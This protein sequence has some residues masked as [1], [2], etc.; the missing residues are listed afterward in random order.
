MQIKFS[1]L[2][3]KE[4]IRSEMAIASHSRNPDPKIK[5]FLLGQ[6]FQMDVFDPQDV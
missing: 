4:I 1:I 5:C 6:T 2:I 3:P